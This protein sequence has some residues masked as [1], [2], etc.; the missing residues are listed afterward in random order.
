MT[1]VSVDL[2]QVCDLLPV[3]DLASMPES[4]D[5][6]QQHVVRNRVDDAVVPHANPESW[7]APQS[8]G[9]RRSWV[10]GEESDRSLYPRAS[11]RIEFA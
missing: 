6:D 11:I 2:R 1:S 4:H 7:P 3:V 8:P 9:C 5:H 10:L